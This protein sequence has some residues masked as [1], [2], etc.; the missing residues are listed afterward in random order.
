MGCPSLSVESVQ[1]S[2][3]AGMRLRVRVVLFQE[4]MQEPYA[5][6]LAVSQQGVRLPFQ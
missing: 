4:P 2:Q 5:S 1:V 6:M 3:R